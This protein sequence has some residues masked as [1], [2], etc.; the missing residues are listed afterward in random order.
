M[1][2]FQDISTFC[3]SE[4]ESCLSS[5]IKRRLKK[6]EYAVSQLYLY[7][8]GL[9]LR[10]KLPL[11]AFVCAYFDEKQY[12]EFAPEQRICPKF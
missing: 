11:S 12:I 10:T 5:I 6:E 3:K 8:C 4:I 7:A 2:A 9:S 1:L